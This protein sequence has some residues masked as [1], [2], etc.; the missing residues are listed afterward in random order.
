MKGDFKL[1]AVD[2][3][4]EYWKYENDHNVY[5]YNM[6]SKKWQY[7]GLIGLHEI[8]SNNPLEKDYVEGLTIDRNKALANLPKSITYRNVKNKVSNGFSFQP[9]VVVPF[10]LEKDNVFDITITEVKE[11]K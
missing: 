7:V 5:L 11:Q 10:L 8:D 9:G 6:I 1:L 3:H 4:I 2:K